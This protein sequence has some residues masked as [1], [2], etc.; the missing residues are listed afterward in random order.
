MTIFYRK[1]WI[2]VLFIITRDRLIERL[3]SFDNDILFS[4]VSRCL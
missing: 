3:F 2:D 1:Q 4:E